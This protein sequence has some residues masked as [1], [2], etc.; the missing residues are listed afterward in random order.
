MVGR[1][2]KK[3]II[4]FTIYY[5]D[6]VEYKQAVTEVKLALNLNKCIFLNRD[7]KKITSKRIKKRHRKNIKRKREREKEKDRERL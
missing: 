1:F 4:N 7:R 6:N 5:R 3:G 2:Y